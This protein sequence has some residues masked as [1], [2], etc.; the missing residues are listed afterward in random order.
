MK[1]CTKC[2]RSDVAFSRNKNS[3]DGLCHQCKICEKEYRDSHKDHYKSLRKLNKEKKRIY[4]LEYSKTD[5]R[6]DA[7]RLRSKKC[8]EE[9][10][11]EAK[12]R[13]K[14]NHAIR[15]NRLTKL[16]FCELCGKSD[17]RIEAHHW[18][19]DE[20]YWLDV[21]WCCTQCHHDIHNKDFKEI[22]EDDY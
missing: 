19:Y 6:K 12:A 11:I 22:K 13:S 2:G 18:N 15:D 8:R 20:Q 21:I 10:P 3:K 1:K 17:C 9:K 14:V 4:D 7:V 5:K 16:C